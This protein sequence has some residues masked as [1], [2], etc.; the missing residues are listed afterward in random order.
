MFNHRTQSLVLVSALTLLT[1][2]NYTAPVAT[3]AD[4]TAGLHASVAS[5]TWLLSGINLGLAA[6]LLSAG[7]LA[8]RHGRKRVL[9]AGIA[10]FA[11]M[12]FAGA[13]AQN[14]LEFT[15]SRIGLGAGSAAILAAGLGLLGSVFPPGPAR[16]RATAV[17]GA[18]LGLGI[19]AGPV[20]TA[21]LTDAI[22]WR[23]PY[24][25]YGL[26]AV[27]LGLASTRLPSGA[28]TSGRRGDPA[29]AISLG[30]GLAA[31]V[32]A[33]IEGRSGWVA[34]A[35]LGLLAVTVIMV[36]AFVLIELG[37]REPMLDLALFR[38]PLFVAATVGALFTGLS[39][40]AEMSF[41]P[42]PLAISFGMSPVD[43]ALVIGIWS[44]VSFV[45]ALAGRAVAQ[46]LG[47]HRQ[48]VLGL[49]TTGVGLGLMGALHH[50]GAWSWFLPGLIVAGIGSGLINAALGGLAIEAVPPELASMGSA[51]TNAARYV[52][53][54][55]G[56]A[57]V[58]TLATRGSGTAAAIDSGTSDATLLTAVMALAGA[59]LTGL[60]LRLGA[61]APA[62]VE[63][64][65]LVASAAD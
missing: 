60:A 54:S 27:A 52:G 22:G 58:F 29:G 24:A 30:I 5:G 49:F 43:G 51:A 3:L 34:A 2:M 46:R 40:I 55:I 18:M 62:P 25:L 41:L 35:P 6:T 26:I 19:A 28:G 23:W 7:G 53:A 47:T 48:L 44:M 10:V 63:E 59:A 21:Q 15:L 64:K 13:A 50:S 14:A 37:I 31:L 16:A 12:T 45:I 61:R 56:V 36:V 11:V 9:L 38:R 57:L 17:W 8:D 39:V 33:L 42:T 32:A 65:S 20:I 1:L 4:T